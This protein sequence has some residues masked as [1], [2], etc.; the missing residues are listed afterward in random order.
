MTARKPKVLVTGCHGFLASSI[1]LFNANRFDFVGVSRHDVD[2]SD[3]AA[4][5]RFFHEQD[6][7]LC[8][9]AA[10]DAT[11]AHCENDPADTHRVNTEAAIQVAQACRDRGKRLIFV[12]TE[13]VFN[14][15]P[16]ALAS[17]DPAT[18]PCGLSDTSSDRTA[19]VGSPAAPFSEDEPTSSV[20]NYGKQKAEV[21]AW[22]AQ[23]MSDY[24][25]VRLSW[26]FGLPMP[27][28][29][30]S[31][32][33]VTNVLHTMETQRPTGFRVHEKR[34]MTYAMH[35]VDGFGTLCS[36]PCGVYNIASENPGLSTYEC[37]QLVAR[38]L[39]YSPAQIQRLILPDTT[40][41]AERPRDFRLDGSKARQLGVSLGTFEEDVEK[42]LRDFGRLA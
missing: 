39:G 28:V 26:Q 17:N 33:I 11:T 13:Q 29:K 27:R 19:T 20:T 32:N 7:D 23:N 30:P 15:K 10:A 22:L 6:F 12:S 37:A 21:D 36:A 14:G 38:K 2:Y 5:D 34:C 1:M 25:T 41:Y 31:P 4:V 24:V 16:T 18:A 9:H 8:L 40:T 3:P 42:C 35:L